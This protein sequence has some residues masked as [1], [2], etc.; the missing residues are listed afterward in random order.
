MNYYIEIANQYFHEIEGWHLYPGYREW[1]L[2]V[3]VMSSFFLLTMLFVW[4]VFLDKSRTVA[5]WQWLVIIIALLPWAWA[6]QQIQ[7]YRQK[8]LVQ[9]V[10]ENYK[11]TFQ[12]ANEC[13]VYLLKQKLQMQEGQFLAVAKEIKEMLEL[14]RQYRSASDLDAQFYFRKL[15]D[16]ESKQ[17][18]LAGLLAMLTLITAL[19]VR[20]SPER[21]SPEA[22]F[23]ALL[24]QSAWGIIVLMMLASAMLFLIC[25]GLYIFSLVL[26]DS[27]LSVMLKLTG[28]KWKGK[29]SLQYF[30]RHLVRYHVPPSPRRAQ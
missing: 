7:K 26:Y 21:A 11:K 3:C 28:R 9:E 1:R 10:N 19:V 8:K 18:V 20:A 27:L 16:P 4:V 5:I 22:A 13:C 25:I 23:F 14:D 12:T 24:D 29:M 15:Y 2:W 6:F 30:V 17:R